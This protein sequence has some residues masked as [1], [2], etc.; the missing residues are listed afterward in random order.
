[1]AHE[2]SPYRAIVSVTARVHDVVLTE[3]APLL[4]QH[5]AE[6]AV[7]PERLEALAREGEGAVVLGRE[8]PDRLLADLLQPLEQAQ[9]L[10]GEKP[11]GVEHRVKPGHGR[12]RGDRCH[13]GSSLGADAGENR[14]SP[15]HPTRSAPAEAMERWPTLARRRRSASDTPR[16]RPARTHIRWSTPAVIV[17][18]ASEA[19]GYPRR[20]LMTRVSDH[21]CQA[22]RVHDQQHPAALAARERAHRQ[23]AEQERDEDRH[24]VEQHQLL[25]VAPAARMIAPA[26]ARNTTTDQ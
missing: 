19:I 2:A 13:S 10:V 21:G 3:A 26:I 4:G 11:L 18:A 25:L 12:L 6:E 16:G 1:M 15:A 23:Q 5:Q 22:D 9:L 7:R 24:R 20:R 8:R 17:A 14:I